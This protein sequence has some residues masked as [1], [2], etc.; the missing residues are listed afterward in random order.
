MIAAG[1]ARPIALGDG[2]VTQLEVWGEGRPILLCVHGITS[3]RRSWLRTARYFAADFRVAAYDQRGHGDS[4]AVAGPM[5]LERSLQ[6]LAAVA[7]ALDGPIRGLI[8]HSWGG[9]VA[10]LGGRRIAAERMIAI[11][12]MLHQAPRTWAADFV[13]DVRDILAIEPPAER[14]AQ[15]RRTFAGLPPIEIDAKVHAMRSMRIDAIV[16][17]GAENG[18]DAGRWD[19]REAIRDYPKPLFMPLAD[20]SDSVVSPADLAFVREHG[21]PNVQIEVFTGEGHTL[22]RT[23]FDKFAA[24][25]AAFLGR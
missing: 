10:V 19:L 13:D 23:A 1:A 18:V 9:A 20:P 14:E 21:G 22:Q 3:S 15:I 25:S 4:A 2:A 16:A 11:D 7:A 12:P 17:L 8:G 5:T 24:A 6:D